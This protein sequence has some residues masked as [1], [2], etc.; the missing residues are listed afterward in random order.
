MPEKTTHTSYFDRVGLGQVI[1]PRGVD[2]GD[3]IREVY[4]TGIMMIENQYQDIIHNARV[5][6]NLISDIVF[7][8][9]TGEYGSMV[10]WVMT[11]HSRMTVITGV[12]I[13]NRNANISDEGE[14]V[15]NVLFGRNR[16]SQQIS[17]PK[18][19]Y[20]V[21][22]T[23]DENGLGV[24]MSVTSSAGKTSFSMNPDGTLDIYA[25]ENFTLRSYTGL[26]FTIKQGDDSTALNF[27]IDGMSYRDKNGNEI[28]VEDGKITI[29]SPAIQL[30]GGETEAVRSDRTQD[31]L[32]DIFTVITQI[33]VAINGLV[34]GTVTPDDL[35][36]IQ[37]GIPRIVSEKVTLD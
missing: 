14:Y 16:V 6:Y 8:E 32:G 4:K 17:G 5:S 24:D 34:P 18:G 7:P 10:V 2:R 13:Q 37:Q 11:E 23:T 29:N 19:G 26:G 25:D 3:Y 12:L 21:S 28:T 31:V 22:V 20:Q 33:S 35:L 15:T 27:N 36:Q 30:G 1:I 9:E